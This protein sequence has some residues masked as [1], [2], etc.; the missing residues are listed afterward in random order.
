MQ[1][2]DQVLLTCLPLAWDLT[3][4]PLHINSR[5]QVLFF[6]GT[7]WSQVITHANGL[8]SPHTRLAVTHASTPH[9]TM[10][11]WAT[12]SLQTCI[13]DCFDLVQLRYLLCKA[14]SGTKNSWWY[15][16]KNIILSKFTLHYNQCKCVKITITTSW[17]KFESIAKSPNYHTKRKLFIYFLGWTCKLMPQSVALG[18]GWGNQ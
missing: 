6:P 11:V 14:T 2:I 16:A 10:L 18:N 8:W 17:D 5:S 15:H 7:S 9:H 12:E 13:H 3:I 1:P 4:T